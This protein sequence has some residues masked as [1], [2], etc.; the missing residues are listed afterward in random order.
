MQDA[1]GA[2]PYELGTKLEAVSSSK[3]RSVASYSYTE[4][5]TGVV[6]NRVRL[7]F[8]HGTLISH[9]G[10]EFRLRFFWEF[11][12]TNVAHT[13]TAYRKGSHYRPNLVDGCGCSFSNFVPLVTFTA[14]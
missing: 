8:G 10:V 6:L 12:I 4:P 14:G 9:F 13:S 11:F 3:C 2:F 1:V 7:L 5:L